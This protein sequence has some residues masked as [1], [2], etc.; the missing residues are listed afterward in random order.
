MNEGTITMTK[1][2]LAALAAAATL[3]SACADSSA[4]ITAAYVSP[5][6]Y[7]AMSCTQ[8]AAEA[9]R[10]ASRTAQIAGIQDENAQNDAALTAVSLILFW[11]AAFFL[12]GNDENRAE[13]SRLKGELEALEQANIQRNCGI[14]FEQAP[15][16]QP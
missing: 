16:A 6:Q 7:S 14:A 4:E 2:C 8:I 12:N 5:T 10:V 3:L 1:T 9:Q 11:P 15:A 13:L